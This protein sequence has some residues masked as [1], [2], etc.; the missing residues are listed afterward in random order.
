LF[1]NQRFP[2]YAKVAELADAQD[3]G[4]ARVG[5]WYLTMVVDVVEMVSDKKGPPSGGPFVFDDGLQLCGHNS[6]TGGPSFAPER[7]ERFLISEHRGRESPGE[8]QESGQA[9]VAYSEYQ[10]GR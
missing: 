5:A 3:L 2:F 6:G 8:K 1:L 7:S 4:F 10:D 9:A